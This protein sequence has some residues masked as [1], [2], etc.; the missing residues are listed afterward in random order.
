MKNIKDNFALYALIIGLLLTFSH[1]AQAQD[2]PDGF[3]PNANNSVL[4]I[5]VQTDGKILI[6]G[7]FTTLRGGTVTRNRI[8]R[9]GFAPTAATVSVGGRVMTSDGRGIRNVVIRL[10][11][12]EGNLR[13]AISN[14]FGY[15]RFNDVEAGATYIL[16]A[17]GK[18][19]SFSQ[20][21]QVL[22]VNDET[23]EVNFI[24]NPIKRFGM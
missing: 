6:G 4:S 1:T 14:S 5:A 22:N 13:T 24:A 7:D 16:T 2:V 17:T 11:D 23:D 19:F 15:Y 18:R 8:A 9:L 12:S 20:P 10:T 3:D 21:T